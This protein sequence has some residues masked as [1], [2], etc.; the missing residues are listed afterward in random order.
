MNDKREK[1]RNVATTACIS[2]LKND[3]FRSFLCRLSTSQNKQESSKL[4]LESDA[5]IIGHIIVGQ[6]IR[7]KLENNL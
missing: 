6:V 1:I 5:K 2:C 7:G 4:K 3:F